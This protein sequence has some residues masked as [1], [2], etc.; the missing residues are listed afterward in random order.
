ML[1]TAGWTLAAEAA[2]GPGGADAAL[3]RTLQDH[4]W[5]LQSATDA[6][7][8]PIPALDLP[9]RA[10][11]MRFDGARLGI[12]GGCNRM[13]GGWQVG[14]HGELVTGRLAATMMACAAPLMQADEA[15]SALLAQ[16][17][18]I[19]LTPGSAPALRL[20]SAASGSWVFVGKPTLRSLY[21]APTRIFLEVAAQRVDCSAPPA[22]G[23]SNCLRVRERFFDDKGLPSAPA[24]EWSAFAGAIDGY[25]H[26]PGVRN[27]LRVDR[28]TRRPPASDGPDHVYVLDLV[29]ESEQ[30]A[31]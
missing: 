15:L 25:T 20:T 30:A 28:Y 16:R 13:N 10:I 18:S 29:V 14:P 4:R 3:A 23:S 22:T 24:G 17:P 5:S 12:E 2:S 26:V 11:V 6:A 21:G 9:G 31:R 7:G 1:A 19:S 27:V 8:K